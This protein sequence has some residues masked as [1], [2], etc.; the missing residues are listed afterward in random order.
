MGAIDTSYTFTATDVITSTKMNNILDQSTITA[1]A[2]IG[3]TLA[4]AS[5]KL[6]IAAGG[7]TPNELANNSVRT[8][9]IEDGAVTQAKVSNMLVPTGAIMPFA[10]NSAPTGWL[11]ANGSAVNR[12][13]YASLFSAISTIYGA[14]DGS[15]TF[16]LPD[17]NGRFVRGFGGSSGSFGA[18]QAAYAGYNDFSFVKDDGDGQTGPRGEVTGVTINS[19]EITVATDKSITKTASVPTI[20]GDTRP[21]NIAMLYCI[22]I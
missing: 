22:K 19:V 6:S 11:A 17:L 5:G 9:A 12:T 4:V 21:V 16:N 15:T 7:I 2:I 18:Q 3:T 1:N 20:P 14:G 13:T 8:I 10:M